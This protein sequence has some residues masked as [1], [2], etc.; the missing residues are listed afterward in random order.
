MTAEEQRITR[1]YKTL[2]LYI[3]MTANLKKE[4]NHLVDSLCPYNL[5]GRFKTMDHLNEI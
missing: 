2:E 3:T 5:L 1:Y 4:K